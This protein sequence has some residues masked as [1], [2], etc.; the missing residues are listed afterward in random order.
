[1]KTEIEVLKEENE[2]LKTEND[3]LRKM[4]ADAAEEAKKLNEP[5]EVHYV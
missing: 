1:M 5:I 2:K 3:R 4:W